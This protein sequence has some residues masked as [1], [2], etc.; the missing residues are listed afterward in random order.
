M[1]TFL[2]VSLLPALMTWEEETT[3]DT[4]GATIVL[5]PTTQYIQR[6]ASLIEHYVQAYEEGLFCAQPIL[7]YEPTGKPTEL[8][9]AAPDAR[10]FQ[11]PLENAVVQAKQY[12][13]E[14]DVRATL[15]GGG[16]VGRGEKRVLSILEGHRR[17]TVETEGLA[18][19][20]RG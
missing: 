11:A 5:Q 18:A 15:L 16:G 10:H 9:F 4:R 2:C 17:Q 13:L 7:C 12:V 20:R 6:H 8:L 3:I 1:H 19:C 14:L